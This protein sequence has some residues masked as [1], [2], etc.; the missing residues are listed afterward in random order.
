MNQFIYTLG[1]TMKTNN[2]KLSNVNLL[3][4]YFLDVLNSAKKST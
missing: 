2:I 1:L 4:D 3:N